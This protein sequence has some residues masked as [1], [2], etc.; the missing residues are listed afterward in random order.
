M[1]TNVTIFSEFNIVLFL[2][3]VR[4]EVLLKMDCNT[5]FGTFLYMVWK[6]LEIGGLVGVE[7][8]SSE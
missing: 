4:H 3:Y 6:V 1:K 2:D 8:A 7:L 5:H